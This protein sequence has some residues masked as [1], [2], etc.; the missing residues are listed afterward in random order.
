VGKRMSLPLTR[1]LVTAA[2]NGSL[3]GAQYRLDPTFRVEVPLTCPDVEARALDPRS[4]WSDPAAYDRQAKDLAG[5]FRKNFQKFEKA[6]SLLKADD[7][8]AIG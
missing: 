6:G 5:R 7:V 3:A 4:T 8:L 2:L 1:A